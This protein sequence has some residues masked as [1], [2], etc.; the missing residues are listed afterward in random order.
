MGFHI[1]HDMINFIRYMDPE[2]CLWLYFNHYA[3]HKTKNHVSP[4]KEGYRFVCELGNASWA[5][6]K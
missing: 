2:H 3:I 4:T 5:T 1:R 6:E